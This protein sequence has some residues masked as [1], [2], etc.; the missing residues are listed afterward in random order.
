MDFFSVF[1]GARIPHV[2][3]NVVA[4]RD[5]SVHSQLRKPWAKGL[6]SASI[7]EY[8]PTI[9][10]RALQLA[11]ELD[12]FAEQGESTDFASWMSRFAFDFM[13]DMVCVPSITNV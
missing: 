10:K 11:E 4:V 1:D 9:Q 3:P 8:S 5:L 13:G 12:K 6:S 7:K 2:P